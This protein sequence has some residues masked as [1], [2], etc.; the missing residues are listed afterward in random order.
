M[1][2]KRLLSACAGA[3]G[4]FVVGCFWP[5]EACGCLSPPPAVFL[6][7]TVVNGTN[8]R[9]PGAQLAA[10]GTPDGRTPYLTFSAG[11]FRTTDSEGVAHIRIDG[12]YGDGPQRIHATIVHNNGADTSVVAGGMATFRYA[13][14]PRLDTVYMTFQLSA[15]R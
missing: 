2:R 15:V 13:Q 9:M 1:T 5:T 14:Y 6:V 11:E 12:D 7:G 8:V 10:R 3:A 4:L